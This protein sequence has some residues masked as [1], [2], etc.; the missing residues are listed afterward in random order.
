MAYQIDFTCVN[1]KRRTIRKRLLR[2]LFVAMVLSVAYAIYDIYKTYNEPTLDMCLNE[3]E[4]VAK[5][6]E[7]INASWDVALEKYNS[8][9]GY[10][11]L[12]WAE[13][14]TNILNAAKSAGWPSLPSSY[15]PLK[16]RFTTGGKCTLDYRYVFSSGD[17]AEQS[18]AISSVMLNAVT[19]NVHG[20]E[21]K[22]DISGIQSENLLNVD[23]LN[24]TVTFNLAG[25]KTF[26]SKEA[27]LSECVKEIESLRTKIHKTKM[28]SKSFADGRPITVRD[29]F[30]KYLAVGKDKSDFPDWKKAISVEGWLDS[31]DRFIVKNRIPGDERERKLLKEAWNKIGNARLPWERY[32]ELDNLALAEQIKELG[33]I[34]DGVKGFRAFL[35]KHREDCRKKLGSFVESYDRS[36]IFNKPIVEND[37]RD[38]VALTTGLEGIN[39]TFKDEPEKER[40]VFVKEEETF[41]FSWVRWRVF[42]GEKRNERDNSGREQASGPEEIVTLEKIASFAEKTLQLGP[43]YA[44]ESIDI[45]FD[46]K[47]AVE[48]FVMT[49]LLPVK[50][51]EISKETQ[52]NVR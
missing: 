52:G 7:E 2:G 46:H 13:I 5:P 3:L 9:I 51:I 49:G 21:G 41:T 35:V 42:A 40:I 43:G 37:L 12:L 36:D 31:A 26:P 10:Y 25:V 16:W 22:V 24:L 14:P 39:I 48:K 1:Y 19:S 33:V 47:G 20:I 28:V 6:I 29:L 38:R 34:A 23:G 8:L 15:H 17:K 18:K 45:D 32:R 30:M 4:A 27:V 44:L 11:R 50:K